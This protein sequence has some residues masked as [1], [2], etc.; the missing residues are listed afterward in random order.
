MP[1]SVNELRE[2]ARLLEAEL[3]RQETSIDSSETK[4]GV[5]A[6]L[7]GVLV[8]L[9]V[10]VKHPNVALRTAEAFALVAALAALAAVFP[11]RLQMPDAQAVRDFYERL[12][13][14]EATS[15]LSNLRLV[16]IGRNYS[17]V[18][19]KRALVSAGVVILVVAAVLSAVAVR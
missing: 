19:S 16:A 15:M 13:E 10:Q 5:L 2:Q 1:V 4:G 7:A 3:S 14:T 18:D 17:I 12:P 6:G 9:L 8:G 11:R